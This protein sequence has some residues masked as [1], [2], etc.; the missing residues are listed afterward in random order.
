MTRFI[1]NFA[2]TIRIAAYILAGLF[3]LLL[4]IS[5]FAPPWAIWLIPVGVAAGA[6]YC[7]VGW[8]QSRWKIFAAIVPGVVAVTLFLAWAFVRHQPRSL[9]NLSSRI[10]LR[11][12]NSDILIMRVVTPRRLPPTATAVNRAS[13][14]N[15]LGHISRGVIWDYYVQLH[16]RWINAA[17][18]TPGAVAWPIYSTSATTTPSVIGTRWMVFV[19]AKII[20][21]P[22]LTLAGVLGL[23]TF[24]WVLIIG[25]WGPLRRRLAEDSIASASLSAGHAIRNDSV[26]RSTDASDAHRG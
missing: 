5:P 16:G 4:C 25:G 3:L 2:G 19:T 11:A 26:A 6:V 24:L 7:A 23:S 15:G 22:A 20:P 1:R 21:V 14:F 12:D 10:T 18:G 9:L 8:R 17:P 13:F